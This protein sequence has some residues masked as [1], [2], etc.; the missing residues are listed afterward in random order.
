MVPEFITNSCLIHKVVLTVKSTGDSSHKAA[1]P[2]LATDFQP[3]HERFKFNFFFC[4]NISALRLKCG[5]MQPLIF[6]AGVE[7]NCESKILA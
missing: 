3:E 5:F 2:V 7:A 6:G 1:M 4:L